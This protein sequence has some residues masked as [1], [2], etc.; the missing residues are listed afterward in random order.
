MYHIL[1]FCF[2]YLM[3]L[4]VVME[5]CRTLCYGCFIS[6]F[7]ARMINETVR[8][9]RRQL[10]KG[11]WKYALRKSREFRVLMETARRPQS[12]GT[13]LTMS[14]LSVFS[15]FLNY[16]LVESVQSHVPWFVVLLAFYVAASVQAFLLLG[17]RLC[18]TFNDETTALMGQFKWVLSL[19]RRFKRKWLVREI[20]A[21]P[22]KGLPLA[23]GDFTMLHIT[24]DV[25]TTVSRMILDHTIRL[26][27]S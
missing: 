10:Q 25:T 1:L 19:V 5:M 14:T 11:D 8:L 13:F 4:L 17:M 26:T 18:V 20:S 15:V 12:Q 9:I 24:K 2:R 21:M 23:L 16:T 6:V 3:C 22:V 7:D 27:L